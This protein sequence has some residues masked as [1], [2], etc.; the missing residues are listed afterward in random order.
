MRKDR[1]LEKNHQGYMRTEREVLTAIRH[2]FVV[3]LH[4]SFQT[5]TRLYLVLDFVNGGHLFF[6]L[7]KQ[8]FFMEDL[9]RFYTAEIILAVSHLHRYGRSPPS[10][11]FLF[12]KNGIAWSQNP[13]VLTHR[14]TL[15]LNGWASQGIMHRDLKPENILLDLEGHVRITDFG[16]AKNFADNDNRSTRSLCG[17]MEYMSPGKLRNTLV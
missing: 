11:L 3:E 4:Y 14:C 13:Q 16:L 5:P 7:Y 17:T 12:K 8:G 15:L 6:Q 2:P 9:A 1:I 10:P